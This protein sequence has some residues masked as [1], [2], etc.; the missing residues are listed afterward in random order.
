[1]AVTITVTFV[2]LAGLH[3]S[4]GYGVATYSCL[5]K[6]H[7]VVSNRASNSRPLHFNSSALQIRSALKWEV[8]L[9]RV[10]LLADVS[11]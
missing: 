10:L 5:A 11:V 2:I 1:M 4:P 3:F 7:Y 8:P 9:E 6:G